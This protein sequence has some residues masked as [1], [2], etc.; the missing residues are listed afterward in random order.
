MTL[1][2]KVKKF[3]L[4]TK[5][6]IMLQEWKTLPKLNKKILSESLKQLQL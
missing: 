1:Q 6:N 2:I 3:K 5:L 4:E